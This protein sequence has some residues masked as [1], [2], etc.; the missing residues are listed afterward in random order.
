MAWTDKPTEVQLAALL[1]W[2]K[3]ATT[4]RKALAALDYL[5]ENANR[6]EVSEEMGRIRRLENEKR[7]DEQSCFESDVWS[8]FIYKK[9]TFKEIMQE[10]REARERGEP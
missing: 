1:N 5:R 9:P 4:Y 8:G 3:R 10:L 7:L 6:R 2:I